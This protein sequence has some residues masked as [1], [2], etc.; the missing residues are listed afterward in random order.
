[1]NLAQM[2]FKSLPDSNHGRLFSPRRE[3]AKILKN[4]TRPK[5]SRLLASSQSMYCFCHCASFVSK[6][7]YRCV[8]KHTVS[9]GGHYMAQKYRK[10]SLPLLIHTILTLVM[11]GLLASACA[12]GGSP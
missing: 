2:Y 12:L 9:V 4:Q 6:V 8:Y 11:I 1:M 3:R 10:E 7:Y 5:Y